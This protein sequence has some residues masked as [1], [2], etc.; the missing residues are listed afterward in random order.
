MGR[1]IEDATI[2]PLEWDEESRWWRVAVSLPSGQ[3]APLFIEPSTAE[4]IARPDSPAVFV[5][6]YPVVAWLREAEQEVYAVVARAMLDVYNDGWNEG[7]PITSAEFIDRI[8]LI[9]VFVPSDGQD[10]TMHFTD[11]VMEMFGGHDIVL[12]FSPDRQLL[13]AYLSG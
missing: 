9:D 12:R 6:A 7:P 4:H 1:V 3:T 5:S 13:R 10:F 2:G 8:S 11:G